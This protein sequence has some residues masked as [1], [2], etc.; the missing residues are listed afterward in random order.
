MEKFA[1]LFR[2]GSK[3]LSDKVIYPGDI[4]IAAS[5]FYNEDYAMELLA[6]CEEAASGDI[7]DDGTARIV[8][9]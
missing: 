2:K 9:L 7:Y 8:A 5:E 1:F 6:W 4:Y 3:R